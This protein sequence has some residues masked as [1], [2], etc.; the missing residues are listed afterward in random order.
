[1]LTVIKESQ[2]C[3][4]LPKITL[5]K[6][7]STSLLFSQDGL[8]VYSCKNQMLFIQILRQHKVLSFLEVFCY[9]LHVSFQIF[10]TEATLTFENLGGGLVSWRVLFCYWLLLLLFSWSLSL[11]VIFTKFNTSVPWKRYS[12][13]IKWQRFFSYLLE[14]EPLS[15]NLHISW[16]LHFVQPCLWNADYNVIVQ[17]RGSCWVIV[18][19]PGI[20][21]NKS[22][23]FCCQYWSSITL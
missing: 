23:S 5:G 21:S 18:I 20:D 22:W 10:F 9:L 13:E 15:Y 19:A 7:F 6:L 14:P 17:D 1:M 2:M 12:C 8:A 3:H 4:L 11:Y 16:C